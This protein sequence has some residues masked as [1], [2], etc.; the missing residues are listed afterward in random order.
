MPNT[1]L[2]TLRALLFS[3]SVTASLS[4]QSADPKSIPVIDGGI[5]PCTADFTIT[6]SSNIP[7]YNAKIKVHIAYG[8]LSIRKLDLEVSTNAD[9]KGRFTG[10]P[11]KLKRGLFFEASQADLQAEAFDDP[12]KNCTAQFTL[13]LQ[14]PQ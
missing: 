8:T 14:K 5:G 6:D 7:I 12:S 4:A 11:N 1:H 3:L 13:A 9:G 10:L 2:R